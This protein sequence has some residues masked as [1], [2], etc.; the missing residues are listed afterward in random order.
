MLSAAQR[1]TLP[2]AA[3]NAG[4]GRFYTVL[5]AARPSEVSERLEG[6]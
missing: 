5:T 2:Q 3:L 4:Q 1:R 6:L